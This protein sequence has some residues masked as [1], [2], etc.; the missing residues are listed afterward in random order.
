[1][2]W[3]EAHLAAYPGTVV[4]VTHDRYFLDNIAQWIL[5]L[6]RGHAYPYQ[7]NYTTYLDTKAARLQVEGRKDAKRLRQLQSEL[8]W[9][10]SAMARQAK[11]ARGC[12]VTKR[13]RRPRPRP[14]AS[15]STRFTFHRVRGWAIWSS[16]PNT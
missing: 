15:T 1:V 16:R 3:L 5:E 4:A 12:A 7:G 11:A 10:R 6:D 2:Q 8:E 13:W 14:A 9:V